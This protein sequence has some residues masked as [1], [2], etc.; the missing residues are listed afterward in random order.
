MDF[1]PF[2]AATSDVVAAD[3]RGRPP[4]PLQALAHLGNR[5]RLPAALALLLLVGVSASFLNLAYRIRRAQTR[6]S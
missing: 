4:E 2:V 3:A 5:F 6:V 1:V